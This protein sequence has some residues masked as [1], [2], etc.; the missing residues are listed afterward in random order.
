MNSIDPML[1]SPA[2]IRTAAAKHDSRAATMSTQHAAL[3]RTIGGITD[4]EWSGS[5]KA[6]FLST[7]D[8]L[9]PSFGRIRNLVDDVA[10]TL[11]SYADD[12]EA[13]QD[14]AASVR[15]AQ[16]N[17]ADERERVTARRSR[18]AR[19]VTGDDAVES[20]EISLRRA[21][22]GLAVLNTTDVQ[23]SASWEALVLRRIAL[24][25]STAQVLAGSGAVGIVTISATGLGGMSDSEFLAWLGKLGPDQIAALAGDEDVAKRLAAMTD[26]EAVAGWWNALGG[27]FGK[28]SKDGSSAAQEAIIAAFPAVIGNLN[29]VLRDGRKD[30]RFAY[31]DAGTTSLEN[32]AIATIDPKALE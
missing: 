9:E 16:S 6:A 21:E 31:L 23:L 20:D 1:G 14:E 17:A 13:I 24:D 4:S 29:G 15:A 7:V 30:V 3:A 11:R 22:S 10:E 5:S 19:V 26:P 2:S 12:V 32:A 27:E 28:D 8:S 25:A 18:L